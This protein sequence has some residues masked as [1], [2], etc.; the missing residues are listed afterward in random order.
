MPI[1][2][3]LSGTVT[4]HFCLAAAELLS[5]KGITKLILV[6]DIAK[7]FNVLG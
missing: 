7:A 6:S 2:S 5:L 3:Q 1:S 4:D